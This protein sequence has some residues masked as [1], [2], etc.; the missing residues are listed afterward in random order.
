MLNVT[1]VH[2]GYGAIEVLHGASLRVEAGQRIG[3]F[4]P[5]GHGKTTL[6]RTISGLLKAKA[7]TIE[8]QGEAIANLRP[9]EIVARGLIHVPQGNVVFPQMTVLECLLLGAYSKRTWQDRQASL[10]GVFDLFP[11][12]KQRTTQQAQSLS[13]GERQ[14]L[15]IGVG[16]MSRPTMLML[17]EPSLGLAPRLIE[18]LGHGIA[19][20]ARSG[21]TMLLIDQNIEMLLD[22]CESLYML[23]Q[24]S[25]SLESE[26]ADEVDEE[27]LLGRY[28][29][30]AG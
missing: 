15:S 16:L 23:E 19:K 21:V 11:K 4:G 2:S 10:E 26:R 7:G 29:G 17:D 5:N 18:E 27:R 13:G 30:T 22:C 20:I 12:L 25:I 24:G 14:M 9:M 3:L 28:F 1:D 8:F 6:L